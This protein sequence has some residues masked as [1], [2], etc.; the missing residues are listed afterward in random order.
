MPFVN[1]NSKHYTNAEKQE[2]FDALLTIENVLAPKLSYLTPAERSSYGSINE[3]NKLI[4]NKVLHFHKTQ[5]ALSS[6]D[7]DWVEYEN[8]FESREFL[9]GLTMR[10]DNLFQGLNSSRI[11]HDW[12]NYRAA[13]TDYDF[14]KYKKSVDAN[15]FQA[16]AEE[17]KQFFTGG[18]HTTATN[19]AEP[20]T[21]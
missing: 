18:S 10:M 19:S 15:G 3:Q 4:V 11:L 13:L 6:A 14:A 9:Q 12:D 1:L 8:D 16:K 17:L 2:V 21:E 5:P 7:V 20:V